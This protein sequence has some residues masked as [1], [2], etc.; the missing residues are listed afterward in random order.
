MYTPFS[1]CFNFHAHHHFP[2]PDVA[3]TVVANEHVAKFGIQLREFV[4]TFE[5]PQ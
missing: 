1:F 3:L 2:S 4:E 5:L